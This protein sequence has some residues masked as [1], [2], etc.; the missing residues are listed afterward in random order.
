[1]IDWNFEEKTNNKEWIL[2]TSELFSLPLHENLYLCISCHFFVCFNFYATWRISE[3]F[4]ICY[5]K[6]KEMRIMVQCP[7]KRFFFWKKEK[8]GIDSGENKVVLKFVSI[9]FNFWLKGEEKKLWSQQSSWNYLPVPYES[10]PKFRRCLL[11]ESTIFSS[12]SG[13]VW[14][15]S[16]SHARF[17]KINSI[18]ICWS[19]S[20]S[21]HS[22]IRPCPCH[23][24]FGVLEDSNKEKPLIDSFW[25]QI[26]L[27][28]SK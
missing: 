14:G 11:L 4:I 5:I 3:I 1:L 17:F 19:I 28:K 27:I 25:A 8:H 13:S 16:R 6:E 15:H 26:I 20:W 7:C 22:S 23:L 12:P 2:T 9:L 10:G 24:C 21:V 18:K